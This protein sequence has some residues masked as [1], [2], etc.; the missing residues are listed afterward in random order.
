MNNYMD[1]SYRSVENKK[2]E[3]KEHMLHDSIYMWFKKRQIYGMLEKFRIFLSPI[4]GGER[5]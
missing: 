4:S 5:N 3:T 1:E 2:S